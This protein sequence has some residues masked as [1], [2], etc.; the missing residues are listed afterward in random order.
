ELVVVESVHHQLLAGR[1]LWL[2]GQREPARGQGLLQCHF[3]APFRV[4]FLLTS[5]LLPF[6]HGPFLPPSLRGRPPGPFR[7]SGWGA[8]LAGLPGPI[9]GRGAGC[10]RKASQ[11]TRSALHKATTVSQDG[12]VTPCSSLAMPNLFMSARSASW[13]WVSPA[14]SRISFSLGPNQ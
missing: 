3:T 10:C 11:V 7:S 13:G 12:F 9:S 8:G 1:V 5:P 6:A 4:H 14:C 2:R